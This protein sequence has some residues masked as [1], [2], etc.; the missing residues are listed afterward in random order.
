MK[1]SSEH[2]SDAP[3]LQDGYLVQKDLSS[4]RGKYHLFPG[5]LLQQGAD[6]RFT[7]IGPGLAMF[8]L[9]LDPE[10]EAQLKPVKFVA[11]GLRFRVVEEPASAQET[12]SSTDEAAL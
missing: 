12:P 9:K 7:K 6:G 2:A 8:G 3:A 11:R 5:D 1:N 4:P 10:H